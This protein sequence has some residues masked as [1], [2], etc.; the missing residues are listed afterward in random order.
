MMFRAKSLSFLAFALAAA[1]VTPASADSFLVFGQGGIPSQSDLFTWC[2]TP[3]CDVSTPVACATPEGGASLRVR[4]N[5]WGGFGVFR[6][7]V[8]TDLSAYDGGDLKFFVKSPENL[9]VEFQCAVGEFASTQTYTQFIEQHGWDGTSTWQELSI[10][11]C[12]F[13]PDGQCQPECMGRVTAP[14]M[15][16]IENLPFFNTFQ[17]DHVRWETA[18][19]HSGPSAVDVQGRQLMVEGEPFVV[20]GVAYSPISIGEDWRAAWGDRPDRYLVDF[21]LIAETGINTV[22][23]YAPLLNAAMLDAAWANG[24]H[25]MPTFQPDPD[26]LACQE[27]RDFMRD[28]LV[29]MVMQWKDHPS[30][31]LWLIGNE[32]NLD[33]STVELCQDWYPQLDALAAAVH[34]AEGEN[35]HPVSTAN[36]DTPALGDVCMAGCSD[37]TTLPNLDLWAVQV[38]RGCS[39]GTLFDEYQKPD[40]AKPL[41]IT[42]FGVD[43]WDSQLGDENET[44]QSDCMASLLEEANEAL[45]VRNSEGVSSG[46]VIFEWADEWWKAN[47]DASNPENTCV[48]GGTDWAAHDTCTSFDNFA[49]P[50]PAIN[51]EWWGITTQDPSNGTARGFREAHGQVANSWKLG[52][53]CDLDI[54]TYDAES[55]A[56]SVAFAPAAGSTDHTLYYG[57]LG[58]V[59][60]YGYTGSIT[61]LGGDGTGSGALPAGDL[62]WVIASRNNGAEGCYGTDSVG[63]ERACFPGDG[64]CAV[65]PDANRNCDCSGR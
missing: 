29:D 8:E 40:C 24:L 31:L 30:I 17:I 9:K 5:V 41:I 36:A 63:S 35:F 51:E 37:D 44:L 28:R 27:G 14:F 45:A 59:S 13:F 21:P 53:A 43:A 1:F 6:Q 61:G 10:P 11:I 42:E 15:S 33:Y 20:N 25:V 12:S 23:V 34:A 3:P 4:T 49:Y 46:Q 50:D 48:E 64:G 18:N 62:F 56:T 32:F 39:F 54:V 7:G 22:R 55:G 58:D 52:A 16:T 38:Y 47:P 26:Q 19:T 60:T 65:T 2:D 57:P